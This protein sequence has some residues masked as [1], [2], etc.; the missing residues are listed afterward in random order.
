[1]FKNKTL[2]TLACIFCFLVSKAQSDTREA[3]VTMQMEA[4]HPDRPVFNKV[5]TFLVRNDFILESIRTLYSNSETDLGTGVTRE[6]SA[7]KRLQ[8]YNLTNYREMIGMSFDLEK[9]VTA[10]SIRTYK[11]SD[12]KLGIRFFNEPYLSNGLSI[13]DLTKD[14]DTI[15]NGTKCFLIKN[16]RVVTAV[17]NKGATEKILQVRIAINP[18]L[19]SYD[20]PFISEKIVQQFGGGA[21]VYVAFLA[22]NGSKTTVRY[23]YSPFTPVEKSLF[24]HYQMIY[25]TNLTLL[26][27]FKKK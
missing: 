5:D 8:Y 19:K 18:S 3:I 11:A 24:D 26:D 17:G 10:K 25:N 6:L 12:N 13:S 1:M 2:L 22:E 9:K 27:N 20:F 21:I 23:N 15:I 4:G 7:G 14:K 16:N